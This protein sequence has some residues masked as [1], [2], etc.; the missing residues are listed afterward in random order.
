LRSWAGET[1]NEWLSG[2][3][4]IHLTRS[5]RDN[6]VYLDWLQAEDLSVGN[7]LQLQRQ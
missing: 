5:A 1:R 2:D 6:D 3:D 4:H 7:F